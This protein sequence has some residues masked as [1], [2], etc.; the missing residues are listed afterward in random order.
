MFT[1]DRLGATYTG[2]LSDQ[3]HR[4]YGFVQN[5]PVTRAVREG[6]FEYLTLES[7]R[8]ATVRVLP[9]P[10]PLICDVAGVRS[11]ATAVSVVPRRHLETY[12]GGSYEVPREVYGAQVIA[13]AHTP[14]LPDAYQVFRRSDSTGSQWRSVTPE[15]TRAAF[16]AWDGTPGGDHGCC[17]RE[18]AGWLDEVVA[19]DPALYRDPEIFPALSAL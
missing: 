7:G 11:E 16:D 17:G 4:P 6:C 18:F 10:A 19:D 1:Y 15:M 3:D 9:D 13:R 12:R 8:T 2:P 5:A 14:N